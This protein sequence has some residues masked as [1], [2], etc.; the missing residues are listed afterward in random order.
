M[1]RGGARSSAAGSRR[2]PTAP[3]TGC[4]F[5]NTST[6]IPA[7]AWVPATRPA[8]PRWW[9]SSSIAP[10]TG[11]QNEPMTET[12]DA[13]DWSTIPIPI[14]DGATRHLI[15]VRMPPIA[16]PATDGET[17]D[18]SGLRGRTVA[19]AYPRTGLPGV[20]NPE[21]WDLIPGARGCT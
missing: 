18:L 12:I 9:R 19:Y 2:G 16:L 5:T 11:S 14:D 13:P 7:R 3:A 21:G 17:V 10:G 8:G 1:A 4:S 15:G 6:A 20:P